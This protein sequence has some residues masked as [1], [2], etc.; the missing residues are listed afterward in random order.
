V[1]R[2]MRSGNRN[3]TGA[4]KAIV[5]HQHI[6]L[7]GELVTELSDYSRRDPVAKPGPNSRPLACRWSECQIS[8]AMNGLN[9]KSPMW[10]G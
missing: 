6:E 1:Q 9:L 10:A 8:S 3:V 4:R 5:L 2:K 7:T